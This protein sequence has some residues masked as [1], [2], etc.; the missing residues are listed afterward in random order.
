MIP[1]L[2]PGYANNKIMYDFD[3]YANE[4][5][6]SVHV[7]SLHF[8]EIDPETLTCKKRGIYPVRK[9]SVDWS[10]T[11]PLPT[12]PSEILLRTLTS[13]DGWN[14]STS[15]QKANQNEKQMQNH[16]YDPKEEEKKEEEEEK[17][18][19]IGKDKEKEKEKEQ[20]EE[21]EKEEN[22]KERENKNEDL[23]MDD[24]IAMKMQ[25]ASGTPSVRVDADVCIRLHNRASINDNHNINDSINDSINDNI[26]DNIND[27]IDNIDFHFDSCF[28]RAI[29]IIDGI[30]ASTNTDSNTNTNT[31]TN[32]DANGNVTVCV[33]IPVRNGQKYLHQ[34]LYSILSQPQHCGPFS[35]II[36]ND[37]STDCTAEIAEKVR[38]ELLKGIFSLNPGT[39]SS[40]K[41]IFTN[42]IF[43]F[44]P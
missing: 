19:E 32:T 9:L 27:S 39:C 16:Y 44:G 40:L 3:K 12:L 25:M 17:E 2:G 36:I 28:P 42:K 31:S 24:M 35:I 18:E 26:N 37:G 8:T 1:G 4:I 21:N 11:A 33:I 43:K 15:S 14:D 23:R 10:V 41:L 34:C 30:S 29:K 20:D 13:E 5:N 38:Q 22:I 7:G 6:L